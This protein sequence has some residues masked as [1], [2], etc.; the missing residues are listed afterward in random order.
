MR[1]DAEVQEAARNLFEGVGPER[2]EEL[3]ALWKR[4]NPRFNILTDAGPE[5]LFVFDAGA[6]R[7]VRF[8]HRAMR[9][10]WLASFV[11]WE[12]YR[13]VAEGFEDS[14]IDLGHFRDMSECFSKMLEEDDPEVVPLPDGIPEP[15]AYPCGKRFPQLRAAAELATFATGW[16]LLHEICHLQ[17]QQD[18]T[19]AAATDPPEKWRA[20]ELSCD[21][22]A[23]KFL[24]D[25]IEKYADA[26]NIPSEKVRQKREVGI[27][28]ALFAM[29]LIGAGHWDQSDSHPAMEERI[30]AVMNEMGCDGTRPSDVIAHMAFAAL[31]TLWPDAP[32]PFK[33]KD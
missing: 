9:A 14:N 30:T 19:G 6:Y 1:N 29:T 20:E 4:Y 3:A 12:G 27:Y 26:E 17:H 15:G 16:A 21:N 18:G 8:N 25:K 11:A 5:G 2:R 13:A 22:Y 28:F 23:T 33:R 31:W 10:F 24:L 32:G 7:D